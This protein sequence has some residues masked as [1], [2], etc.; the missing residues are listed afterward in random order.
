MPRRPALVVAAYRSGFTLLEVLIVIAIAVV[1]GA[2]ALPSYNSLIARQRLVA[3]ASDLQVDI[4][5][6]REEAS[7]RGQAVYLVFRPGKQWCYAI[8]THAAADCHGQAAV[9]GGAL[10]KVVRSTDH[11][12]IDLGQAT[13][14]ALDGR[15]G[16]S[17][18]GEGLARFASSHGMQLQVRLGPLGRSA[19]CAPGAPVAG[20]PACPAPATPA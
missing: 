5:L 11:P 19:V 15:I 17:L 6:A 20:T 9:A 18:L 14:M 12:G 16:A 8:S 3:T 1:L 10:I 13:T 2:M 4:S 7:R